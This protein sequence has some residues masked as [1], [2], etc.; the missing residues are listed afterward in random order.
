MELKKSHIVIGIIGL[1][2]LTGLIAISIKLSFY[3]QTQLKTSGGV[4]QHVISAPTNQTATNVDP[5][6]TFVLNNFPII[7][8][9]IGAIIFLTIIG[10]FFHS[11]L[12][13][14]F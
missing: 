2:I 1:I 5:T 10:N 4:E 6:T 14:G 9:F 8:A 3:P 13:Y 12:R 11:F 7:F